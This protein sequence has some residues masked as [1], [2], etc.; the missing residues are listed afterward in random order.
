M[1]VCVIVIVWCNV[2]KCLNRLS[3]F[4]GMK[5]TTQKTT[6]YQKGIKIHQWNGS[7]LP[8]DG[9]LE[10]KMFFWLANLCANVTKIQN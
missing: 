1:C 2:A 9:V 5:V 3:Y 7:P 8:E 6:L 10:N 4:F